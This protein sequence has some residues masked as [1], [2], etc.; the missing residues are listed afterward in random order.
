MLLL[1]VVLASYMAPGRNYQLRL[2]AV[3]AVGT[4]P[5]AESFLIVDRVG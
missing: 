4:G 5:W 1:V 2:V 3:N